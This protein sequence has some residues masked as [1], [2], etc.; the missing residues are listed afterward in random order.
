M[1]VRF[2]CKWNGHECKPGYISSTPT[3]MGMCYTFNSDS[4]SPLVSDT[5]GNVNSLISVFTKFHIGEIHD[6]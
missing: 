2:R 1:H 5:T 3:D 6:T 4:H